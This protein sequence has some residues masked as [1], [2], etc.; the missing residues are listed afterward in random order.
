MEN[1]IKAEYPEMYAD[2]R[3]IHGKFMEVLNKINASKKSEQPKI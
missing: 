3:E 1:E 2:L